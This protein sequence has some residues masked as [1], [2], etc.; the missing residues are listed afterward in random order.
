[1]GFGV[2]M[3]L[4]FSAVSTAY[5]ITMTST[6]DISAPRTDVPDSAPAS[7]TPA[8][9]MPSTSPLSRPARVASIDVLRGIVIFT[10]IVVNDIAGVGG[11]VPAWLKHIQ[12]S[13]ADGMTLA[14]VV[15]P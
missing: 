10:M 2:L 13:N 14:D 3:G 1:M 5:G 6:L 15:F 9:P 12:P 8:P 11:G 4:L 7:T